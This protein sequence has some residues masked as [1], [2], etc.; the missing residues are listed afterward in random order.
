MEASE[1]GQIRM[2]G[3]TVA[4]PVGPRSTDQQWLGECL[5]S[6][7]AQTRKADEILLVDDMAGLSLDGA[8]P[9]SDGSWKVES[10]PLAPC[11]IWRTPWRSGV[12]AVMNFGVALA[13]NNLVLMLCADDLLHPECLGYCLNA[14]DNYDP[15]IRDKTFFFL[16]VQYLDGRVNDQQFEPCGAAMVTKKFWKICGGFPPEGALGAPDAALLSIL[17]GNP[18]IGNMVGVCRGKL[19]YYCRPHNDSDT[20]AKGPNWQGAIMSTRNYLTQEWKPPEWGRY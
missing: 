20:A 2:T 3:I 15:N 9:L 19:L 18:G 6:V 1:L 17:I 13:K 10:G 4:I 14:Y 16:G 12:A 8:F 5:Q 7:H 11:R